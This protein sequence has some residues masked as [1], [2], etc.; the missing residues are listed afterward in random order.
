MANKDEE[1]TIESNDGYSQAAGKKKSVKKSVKK[2]KL[3]R[4]PSLKSPAFVK[5]IQKKQAAQK[6]SIAK[7]VKA[8]GKASAIKLPAMPK[9]AKEKGGMSTGA[10]IGLFGGGAIV[11]GLLGFLIYKAVKK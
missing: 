10:K 11:L 4:A 8:I 9:I 2:K 7:Q 6:A 3:L 5:K 1:F